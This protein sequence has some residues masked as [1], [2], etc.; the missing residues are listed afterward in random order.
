MV[1]WREIILTWEE[2]AN[3]LALAQLVCMGPCYPD[4]SEVNV[5]DDLASPGK[6]VEVIPVY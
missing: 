4:S 2:P 1:E 3:T 6:V 5:Q